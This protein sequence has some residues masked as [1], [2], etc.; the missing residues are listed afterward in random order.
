MLPSNVPPVRRPGC[1]C[2]PGMRR[3]AC[4]SCPHGYRGRSAPRAGPGLRA[5][6]VCLVQT[7]QRDSRTGKVEQDLL[8]GTSILSATADSRWAAERRN[9][10]RGAHVGGGVHFTGELRER[11]RHLRTKITEPMLFKKPLLRICEI[12]SGTSSGAPGMTID[13][14]TSAATGSTI[15]RQESKECSTH[16]ALDHALHRVVVSFSGGHRIQP[17]VDE[18]AASSTARLRV[19]GTEGLHPW[20]R[21]SGGLVLHVV[22][23]HTAG[24]VGCAR[25]GEHACTC[26]NMLCIVA[27]RK[28][29]PMFFRSSGSMLMPRG[30]GRLRRRARQRGFCALEEAP[31]PPW[32]VAP[33]EGSKPCSCIF[34]MNSSRGSRSLEAPPVGFSRHVKPFV[35]GGGRSW[36]ARCPATDFC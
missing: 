13:W 35:I 6:R 34:L 36:P 17:E 24:A 4:G 20:T 15:S 28:L 11:L 32:P 19:F 8:R 29:M 9:R 2:P 14:V 1:S 33:A 25:A 7:D 26:A 12:S 18:F 3:P 16:S 5:A 21:A 10:A 27:G 22:P 31:L 23:V 30:S